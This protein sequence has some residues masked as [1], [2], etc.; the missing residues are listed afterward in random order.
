MSLVVIVVFWAK[1][2]KDLEQIQGVTAGIYLEV[3]R[4]LREYR[5]N[6]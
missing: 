1:T 6:P 3:K 4:T 2:R 5:S